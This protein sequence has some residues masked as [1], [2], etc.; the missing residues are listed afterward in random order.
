MNK[1]RLVG[2]M[3]L[4]KYISINCNKEYLRIG[5]YTK[6]KNKTLFLHV[7]RHHIFMMR[8]DNFKQGQRCPIC[9][10]TRITT[11][12]DIDSYISSHNLAN[13]R[14]ITNV[15]GVDTKIDIL[16]E[17]PITKGTVT[18]SVTPYHFMHGTRCKKCSF[19]HMG[20][21]RALSN[22]QFDANIFNIFGD[23]I[24]RIGNYKNSS[25]PVIMYCKLH[26]RFNALY[27][28]LS[29]GKGCPVC[30]KSH[31][32]REACLFLDRLNIEYETQKKFS[33]CKD[34]R[35]LPFDVFIPQYNLCIECDGLQH[36]KAMGF[37]GGNDKLN[38][39]RHHDEIKNNFCCSHGISLL[40]IK[41]NEEVDVAISRYINDATM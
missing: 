1:R 19:Y 41:Y 6:N 18:I 39:T 8:P 33:G 29:A 16:H 21:D 7:T 3:K 9:N 4:D 38:Y 23:D 14:R 20:R 37:C 25:T 30:N 17:C 5:G 32:E 40:R 10:K 31:M 34:K 15:R 22:E 27:S 13:Y 26:G 28:N 36:F 11:N 2:Q 35:E 24:Y 12:K